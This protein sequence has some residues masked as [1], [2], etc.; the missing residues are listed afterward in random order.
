V[1]LA[2]GRRV[3]SRAV[4]VNADPFKLRDLVGA[5]SFPK[6]FNTSLDG[7]K[8]DGTTLKV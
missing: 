8:R 5:H 4:V 2:D 7:M 6:D 3:K 1:R